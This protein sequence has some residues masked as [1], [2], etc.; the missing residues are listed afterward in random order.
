MRD[1][2]IIAVDFDG[3]LSLDAVWP[4]IGQPN[5][6]LLEY[7]KMRKNK[8]DRIILWTCRNGVLLE[9]AV[10][11][12]RTQGLVFDAVNDNLQEVI[13]LYGNNSRKISADWYIDDKCIV[14]GEINKLKHS[15]VNYH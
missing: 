3:T 2:K 6:I 9:E 14:P 13:E 8:G 15:I 4:K 10:E 5:Y 12:C 1:Y 7:L 11:W